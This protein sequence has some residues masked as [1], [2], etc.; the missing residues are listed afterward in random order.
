M[1]DA[2]KS[3]FDEFFDTYCKGGIADIVTSFPDK[4]SLNID[5]K[6][7]SRFDPELAS[8]LIEN[9]DTIMEAALE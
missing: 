7:L 4:R 2:I 1:L 5:I 9:P 8:E 3:K 6:E